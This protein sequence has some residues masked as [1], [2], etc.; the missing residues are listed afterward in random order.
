MTPAHLHLLVNHAPVFAFAFA[1]PL[2][3]Y[4]LLRRDEGVWRA[5]V[6]LGVVGALGAFTALQTGEGAEEF[7][8][9]RVTFSEDALHV[10]EERAEVA[11]VIS[12]VA[13]ALTALAWWFRRGREGVALGSSLVAT[14]AAAG[15]I[16][17]AAH[18]GGPIRHP[19]ELGV[20]SA[21]VE[22]GE[23]ESRK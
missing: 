17:W 10:H 11:T 14:I 12:V 1:L 6:F 20:A 23:S 8:E 9:E 19:E 2:F 16:A 13:G 4:V 5:A 21:A 3:L 22:G 18:A 15:S 7:L